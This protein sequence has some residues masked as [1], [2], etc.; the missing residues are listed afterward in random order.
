V[1]FRLKLKKKKLWINS[2]FV[3]IWYRIMNNASALGFGKSRLRPK[4]TKRYMDK[5]LLLLTWQ[6]KNLT[7]I[8]RASW[9][10]SGHYLVGETSEF[11]VTSICDLLNWQMK[12]QNCITIPLMIILLCSVFLAR[13]SSQECWISCIRHWISP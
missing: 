7:D 8:F 13:P 5:K 4:L 11:Q 12:F 6:V 2:K 3:R 10:L 9:L 1:Y